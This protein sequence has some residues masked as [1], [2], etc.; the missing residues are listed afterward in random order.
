[1]FNGDRASDLRLNTKTMAAKGSL[2][3]LV[4][5]SNLQLPSNRVA[6][7]HG[8]WRT[9][10]QKSQE[11]V[12]VA[13]RWSAQ[14]P[15]EF[16]NCVIIEEPMVRPGRPEARFSQPDDVF[17]LSVC[18][19]EVEPT[20]W[21]RILIPQD[22][23][24]PRFHAVLQIVM[25]WSDSHLHQFRVGELRFGEPTTEFERGPIDHR[26]ITL[27]QILPRRGATCIYEYDFGDGW[28]HLIELEEELPA[29]AVAARLPHCLTGERAC[30]PEDCGGPHG[31]VDF[32]SAIQDLGHPEHH[33]YL[34]WAGGSF[35]PEAFD[36]DRANR[37]L[38]RL[39]TPSRSGR[40][41]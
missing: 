16:P 21:R 33:A 10:R 37:L 11:L 34:E 38:R 35:D 5:R 9:V 23:P 19:L 24:L 1:M 32:L 7:A 25:G 27:N 40:R 6:P 39:K 26:R 29:Q 36:L 14:T 22:I 4:P 3:Q 31:Y 2:R 8:E 18:L 30:P 28:E 15:A 41:H 12:G 20:I 13:V 17:Q